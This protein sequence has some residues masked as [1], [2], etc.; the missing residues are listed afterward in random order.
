MPLAL[1]VAL[2]AVLLVSAR[3][4]GRRLLFK[5][6]GRTPVAFDE[7]TRVVLRSPD[8]A[9]VHAV[10]LPVPG[11]PVV[12]HFHDNTQTVGDALGFARALRSHGF[13][14]VLVE[15]RGYGEASGSPS[16]DALYADAETVLGWLE[17]RGIGRDRIV[18][19][20]R[21]LGTGVAAEMARRAHGS[22]LV[23]IAPFT[24]IPAIVERSV[25]WA[26]T[27][28]LVADAF[29]TASKTAEIRV[30]TMIIHGDGDQV[31]PY[32]HGLAL[33]RAIHDA[34]LVRVGGADHGNVLDGPN[35]LSSIA[36]FARRCTD[37]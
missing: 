13:A 35:A 14:V 27:R 17:G 24:S 18:L 7:G 26:P 30:P 1:A 12:V 20:G 33:S 6:W 36:S 11:A 9:S 16:E 28:L 23:L 21:S 2:S 5:G 3:T 19:S 29:D 31:V 4:V 15:Y 34:V 10:E 8:G 22:A 25:P 37:R 32:E